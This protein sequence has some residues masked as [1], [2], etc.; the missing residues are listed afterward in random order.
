MLNDKFN[1]I[2]N[3]VNTMDS[4]KVSSKIQNYFENYFHSNTNV[5]LTS[6]L[7]QLLWF[8]KDSTII[9]ND[10]IKIESIKYLMER[11]KIIRNNIKQ[12][13]FSISNCLNK[14]INDIKSKIDFLKVIS[15]DSIYHIVKSFASIILG[16]I[17]IQNIIELNVLEMNTDNNK[18]IEETCKLLKT[19]SVYDNDITYFWFLNFL[20]IIFK[21][22]IL[23]KQSYPVPENINRLIVF[24]ET[25]K[26]YYNIKKYYGFSMEISCILTPIILL[27]K[28]QLYKIIKCNNFDEI[29]YIIGSEFVCKLFDTETLATDKAHGFDNITNIFIMRIQEIKEY[30][31][32]NTKI[33]LNIYRFCSRMGLTSVVQYINILYSKDNIKY[34]ANVMNDIIINGN[35][36]INH[37][38][39]ILRSQDVEKDLFIVY[40]NALLSKRLLLFMSM[41]NDSFTKR[42]AYERQIWKLCDSEMH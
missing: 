18:E 7:K 13:Q 16:D 26:L 34:I 28:D 29:N 4:K 32:P 40:Y 21:K 6:M 19:I 35:Y 36:D 9:I 20:G 24:N 14:V 22:K 17:Y 33:L 30:T 31:I 8:N 1:I 2:E 3:H 39:S 15:N 37:A 42:I 38:I 25:I 11:R 12:S 23:E 41:D 27:L 5:M 10:I